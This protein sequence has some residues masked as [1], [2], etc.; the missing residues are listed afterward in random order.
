[1][2]FNFVD[3]EPAPAATAQDAGAPPSRPQVHAHTFDPR[4]HFVTQD[5]L[6]VGASHTLELAS[7]DAVD[8]VGEL[9]PELVHLPCAVRRR[10]VSDVHFEIASSDADVLQQTILANTDL[11][12]GVYEGGLKTWECSVDLA[13]YALSSDLPLDTDSCILEL[14]CGSALPALAILASNRPFAH[15]TLQDYNAEVLQVVTAPNV[16]LSLRPAPAANEV[17]RQGLYE[18]TLQRSDWDTLP[19]AD[20]IDFV[21]GDWGTGMAE[22]L[23]QPAYDVILTSETIYDE[24]TVPA[25][26]ELIEAKLAPSGRALV[27]AK[28]FYFGVGGGVRA[29][30]SR[31]AA[32]GKMNVHVAREI[33]SGGVRREILELTWR[34]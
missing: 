14:G 15:M 25:L 34:A 1:M 18:V 19:R 33:T 6:Q 12:K 31:V 11:V 20:K 2:F 27:A 9:V 24:A 16:L 5:K 22:V 21:A 13:E 17:D 8:V 32:R 10:H 26:L 3:T 28:T 4:A 30:E 23:S 7:G 29:F